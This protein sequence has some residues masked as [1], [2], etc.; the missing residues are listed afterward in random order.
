MDRNVFLRFGTPEIQ[1]ILNSICLYIN[2]YRKSRKRQALLRVIYRRHQVMHSFG[3]DVFEGFVSGIIA[4]GEC[5]E[6]FSTFAAVRYYSEIGIL[7]P[8]ACGTIAV[9]SIFSLKKLLTLVVTMTELSAKFSKISY[10]NTRNPLKGLP[11]HP[12]KFDICFLKSCRSLRITLTGK[13]TVTKDTFPTIARNIV[14]DNV[15]NLLLG[16]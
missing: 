7:A 13:I 2:I 14:T 12:T 15:I 5:V 9:I 4:L 3:M 6:I 1:G 11:I 10:E 8:A 16:F